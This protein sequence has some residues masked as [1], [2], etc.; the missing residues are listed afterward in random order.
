MSVVVVESVAVSD[1][2][3]ASVTGVR[4]LLWAWCR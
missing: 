3:M 2:L 4:G 1:C